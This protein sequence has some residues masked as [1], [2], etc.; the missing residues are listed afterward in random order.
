MKKQT[1]FGLTIFLTAIFLVFGA[2]VSAFGQNAA[3]FKVGD[4][5]KASPLSL[6]D[7]KYWRQCTVIEVLPNAYSVK[8]DPQ[9]KGG[10]PSSYVVN[11][12]WVEASDERAKPAEMETE[13]QPD[14]NTKTIENTNDNAVACFASDDDSTGKTALEKSFRGAIISGF[15][16][17]PEPGADGRITVSVESIVIGQSHP[18]RLYEDPNEARGKTIY[19]V[20]AK[21]TTCTDYNRRIVLVKRERAFSCYKNTAGKWVCDIFAAANTNIKDETKSIDKPR[22]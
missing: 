5:V 19:S 15:E 11:A 21:F 14:R 18:Y 2:A 10:S 1:I 4:R 12:A 3:K 17:E 7:P 8:C 6:K 16:R 20:K 13:E 9:Y 22:Q